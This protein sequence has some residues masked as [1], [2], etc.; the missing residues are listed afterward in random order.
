MVAIMMCLIVY[1]DMVLHLQ[2]PHLHRASWLGHSC[3]YTLTGVDGYPG[4]TI[5][6]DLHLIAG[7]GF[8]DWYH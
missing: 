7:L 1:K 6:G 3:T 8:I 2:Y 4:I 5:L